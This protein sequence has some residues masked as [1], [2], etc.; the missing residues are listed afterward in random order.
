[1]PATSATTTMVINKSHLVNPPAWRWRDA[2][3]TEPMSARS[4]TNSSAGLEEIHGARS[5]PLLFACEVALVRGLKARDVTA[6]GEAPGERRR[7]NPLGLKGRD[8]G[9]RWC[10]VGLS[11]L[12]RTFKTGDLGLRSS[13]SLQPRL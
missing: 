6:W 8:L 5:D 2:V 9:R 10:G 7:P 1:M 13:D 3:V 12:P 11:G 4:R